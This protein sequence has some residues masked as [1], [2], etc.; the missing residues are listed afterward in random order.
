MLKAARGTPA[1]VVPHVYTQNGIV[2]A[3]DEEALSHVPPRRSV[4]A[5]HM[6][7]S[8]RD[9]R[10]IAVDRAI[11]TAQRLVVDSRR[12]VEQLSRV[13]H[14]SSSL[15]T[16]IGHTG[17]EFWATY[18][19]TLCIRGSVMVDMWPRIQVD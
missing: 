16:G 11:D 5:R 14:A 19:K 17:P 4:P 12:H 8:G 9:A 6:L 10:T 13:L 7:G 1:D 18:N 2:I 15:T 3:G